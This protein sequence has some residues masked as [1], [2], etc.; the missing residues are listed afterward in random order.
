MS[1]DLSG[2]LYIQRNYLTDLSAIRTSLGGTLGGSINGIQSN[3]NDLHTSYSTANISNRELNNNVQ[4]VS[5]ILDKE[6]QFLNDKTNELNSELMNQQRLIDLNDSQRKKQTYYNY[7]V[8]VVVI[9]LIL[10]IILINIKNFFPFIPD[11]II[12]FLLIILFTL[13]IGYIAK[14]FYN[15]SLRD[16]MDFDKISLPPPATD[17]NKVGQDSSN[18]DNLIK[19]F[20]NSENCIGAE[21]CSG[22]LAWNP[23]V[24]KCDIKCETGKYAYN[25]NCITSDVCTGS[26]NIICGN[27]CIPSTQKC[28]SVETMDILDINKDIKV[29][30]FEPSEYDKYNVY[31]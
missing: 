1:F 21:C 15:I 6:K 11:F 9:T 18:S 7:I 22:N 5:E 30:P 12:S 31:K 19:S 27:S 16:H 2:L 25:G 10:F 4:Q 13:S 23:Y 26:N 3:L 24:N 28:Y 8:I 14:L 29:K 17:D 20:F